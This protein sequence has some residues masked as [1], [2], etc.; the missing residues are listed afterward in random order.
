MAG[1]LDRH[2][3]GVRCPC[4]D[5]KNIKMI[6]WIRMHTEMTCVGCWAPI[7]LDTA[8]ITGEIKRVER[9]L[10]DFARGSD[11]P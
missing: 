11:K 10:D 8:E 6:G 3:L 2:T 5:Y 4:C 9:M 7:T 1:F